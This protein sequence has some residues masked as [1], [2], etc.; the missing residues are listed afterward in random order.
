MTDAFS[1]GT[2]LAA[3]IAIV[4]AVFVFAGIDRLGDVH[5]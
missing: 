5:A 4:L 1:D 2:A 3:A